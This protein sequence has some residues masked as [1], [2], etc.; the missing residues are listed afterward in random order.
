MLFRSGLKAQ[1]KDFVA[2]S[3]DFGFQ[4]TTAVNPAD[5][6][7][8]VASSNAAAKLTVGTAVEVGVSGATVAL[9]VHGDGKLA[10]QATGAAALSLGSGFATASAETL[11][12]AYNNTGETVDRTVTVSVD[13]ISVSAPLKVINGQTAVVAKGLKA[14]VKDFVTLRSESTR[15]NSSH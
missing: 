1:V 7:L 4:K 10:L 2:L 12:V 13:G 9:V 14:Q 3:G 15:L 6:E 8:L 11:A 5:E